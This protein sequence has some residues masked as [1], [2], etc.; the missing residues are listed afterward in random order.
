MKPINLTPGSRYNS[1]VVIRLSEGPERRAWL[2]LCDCGVEKNVEASRLLSGHI[3]SCGCVGKQRR[4]DGTRRAITT[5]GQSTSLQYIAWQLMHDRCENPTNENYPRYG[6]RGVHVCPRWRNY[7]LFFEDMGVRPQG[8]TLDRI[9]NDGNY[10][11]R[12]CRWATRSEQGRNKSTNRRITAHGETH[13]LAE[14]AE[15]AGIPRERIANRLR[16]GWSPERAIP[17]D[18]AA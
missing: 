6:G 15:I 4:I 3:I 12:N 14:W 5:H 11:P 2:C 8:M 18:L 1:L 16:R 7:E 10:E 9:D 17:L 13:V